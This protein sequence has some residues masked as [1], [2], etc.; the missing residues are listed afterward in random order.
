MKNR[1][2]QEQDSRR[3][4]ADFQKYKEDVLDNLR[5]RIELSHQLFQHTKLKEITSE[6]VENFIE[7]IYIHSKTEVEIK[8][9]FTDI[10]EKELRKEDVCH[11]ER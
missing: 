5:V 3:K 8:F 10:F 7:G 9:W 11:D 4:L 6:I 2:V 1:T